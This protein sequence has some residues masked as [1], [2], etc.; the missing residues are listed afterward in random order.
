VSTA[1]IR[2]CCPPVAAARFP[3]A[4]GSPGGLL[5]PAGRTVI[6]ANAGPKPR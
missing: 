2:S 6:L 4:M 3:L 5:V 1:D